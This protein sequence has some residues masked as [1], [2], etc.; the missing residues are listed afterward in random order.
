M[1]CH[2]VF[3]TISVS[4]TKGIEYKRMNGNN[5]FFIIVTISQFGKDEWTYIYVYK[6]INLN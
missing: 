6:Y 2:S 3:K 4:I 5:K 1:F